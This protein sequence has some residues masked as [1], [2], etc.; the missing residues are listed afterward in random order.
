MLRN[1]VLMVMTALTLGAAEAP[2]TEARPAADK[3]AFT[4]WNPTPRALLREMT[5][6]RPDKTESPFTVDAGHVQI[7]ADLLNYTYDRINSAR[8][9]TRTD[10]FAIAPINFKVGLCTA[11]DF[12]VIVPTYNVT[13]T[14][15]TRA[16]RGCS[17]VLAACGACR[18]ANWW[19][20]EPPVPPGK[21]FL[22][23]S[24]RTAIRPLLA[25]M[26]T[27]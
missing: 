11:T 16:R 26:V 24:R 15:D 9:H 1:F 23:P 8:D 3:A 17:H 27:T 25:G 4:L 22:S 18:E 6:D 13:R 19:E 12:Q 21:A 10:T 14:H 7:E 5:T 2:P 20:R